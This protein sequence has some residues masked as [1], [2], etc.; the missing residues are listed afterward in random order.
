VTK[1]QYLRRID[2]RARGRFGIKHHPSARL[3]VILRPG[4]TREAVEKQKRDKLLK[5]KL[6]TGP[7]QVRLNRPIINMGLNARGN[8][9]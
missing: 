2:I 7:G 5:K 1:G 4:K 9:W 8:A 6:A 3:H